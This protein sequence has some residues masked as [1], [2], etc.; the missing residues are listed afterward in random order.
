[1]PYLN[2]ILSTPPAQTE[3]ARPDQV[4]NNAGGFVFDIG[5]LAQVKRFLILGTEGGT[6]YADERKHTLK[7]FGA[8]ERAVA[9]EPLKVL[10]EVVRISEGA[11]A[12]K[13][14]PTI[15]TF[16]LLTAHPDLEVRKAA[17]SH[18]NT[19]IRTGGHLLTL[20]SFI[21]G[22]RG[23]GKLLKQAFAKWY[24][25][26]SPRELVFQLL[27]YAQ[28]DG[29]TQRDVLRL[30]K[31]KPVSRAQNDAFGFA[32][33]KKSVWKGETSGGREELEAEFEVA[34]M[35]DA[36]NALKAAKTPAESARIITESKLPHEALLSEHR[37]SREVWEAL[38]PNL[39][40][41]ALIRNLSTLSRVGVLD[42]SDAVNEVAKRLVKPKGTRIH[43]MRIL[44]AMLAYK[45]GKGVKGDT[46][47]SVQSK[48]VSA[49]SEAF[50]LAFSEVEPMGQRILIGLD[51]SGSMS[52]P[53]LGTFIPARTATTALASIW[54]ETEPHVDVRA[55]SGPASGFPAVDIKGR[56]LDDVCAA[57]SRMSFNTTDCAKPMIWA[58]TQNQVYD[59]FVVLTDNE[60]FAGKVH[61]FMALRDYRVRKNP[62]AKLVVLATT[63]TP[64]TI[65]DPTD[66]G[67][68][69]I[70]GFSADVPAAVAAFAKGF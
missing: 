48:I 40:Y 7:A 29:W 55:F 45:A 1:M 20:A 12:M 5:D 8:L 21:K 6:Y 19:V 13:V 18:F 39:P 32:T 3:K 16:V 23:W 63:A 70:A 59:L 51:V 37:N 68:L 34:R 58:S 10:E 66:P 24:N 47:W 53:I 35:T 54:A 11:L 62:K 41:H 64:F 30:A 4:Q 25:S 57:T 33:G 14:E 44:L 42:R 31:P 22:R 69:D 9:A 43:P 2:K 49:L 27:K 36:F 65:A 61:P 38:L 56:R 26:R 50:P 28:R 60:T 17:L 67:M 15:L 52:S 46:T